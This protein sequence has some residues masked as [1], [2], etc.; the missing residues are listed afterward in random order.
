MIGLEME[1]S[2]TSESDFVRVEVRSNERR[3][4]KK[5]EFERGVM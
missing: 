5:G 1:V 2:K 3:S 4:W